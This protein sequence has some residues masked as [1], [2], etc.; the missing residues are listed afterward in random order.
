MQA[1][2][3]GLRQ[4]SAESVDDNRSRYVPSSI[5]S[6]PGPVDDSPA[7]GP[8]STFAVG[9]LRGPFDDQ[10]TP[11]FPQVYIPLGQFFPPAQY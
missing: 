2:G 1:F 7:I 11:R 9:S 4:S 10:P 3:F 5:Y 8:P 6:G